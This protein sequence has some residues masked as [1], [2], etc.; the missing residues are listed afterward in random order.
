[1]TIVKFVSYHKVIEKLYYQGVIDT[2]IH[3]SKHHVRMFPEVLKSRLRWKI[4]K[5]FTIWYPI[6]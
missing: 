6:N 5:Q 2:G 1:M 4:L 3:K